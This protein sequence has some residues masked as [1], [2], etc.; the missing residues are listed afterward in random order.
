MGEREGEDPLLEVGSERV[1]HPQRTALPDAQS[2]EAPAVD[3]LLPAV[4]GRV[5]HAHRPTGG[6]N[7]DLAC[8]REEAQAEAEE[9]VIIRH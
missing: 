6:T 7:A 2:L 5:V 1:R 4:V 8:E 9:D 3:L